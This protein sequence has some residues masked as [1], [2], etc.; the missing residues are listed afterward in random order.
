MRMN[1]RKIA[2]W[3]TGAVVAALAATIL[4][5]YFMRVPTNVAYVS[6]EDGGI[7]VIDLKSLKIVRRVHPA[8]VAPRGLGI[9]YDGKYLITSNKDTADIAVFIERHRLCHSARTHSGEDFVGAQVGAGLN[10]HR[11]PRLRG[12]T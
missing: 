12:S 2:F 1:E 11:S 8:D 9:T 3:L 7:S 6:E 10:G 4:R 5:I